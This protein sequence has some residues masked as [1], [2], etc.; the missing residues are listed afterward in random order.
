[1]SE[2][3]YADALS[4]IAKPVRAA[5]D[6]RILKIPCLQRVKSPSSK[7]TLA[8]RMHSLAHLAVGQ[9]PALQ[10]RKEAP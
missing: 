2:C 3:Q 1:M 9:I 7:M 8:P 4:K 6:Y 10:L 5:L